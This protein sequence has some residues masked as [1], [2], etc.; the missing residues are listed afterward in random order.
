MQWNASRLTLLVLLL[1]FHN[2]SSFIL[3]VKGG[4]TRVILNQILKINRNGLRLQLSAIKTLN[5][6][7]KIILPKQ[8]C[9]TYTQCQDCLCSIENRCTEEYVDAVDN[10]IHELSSGFAR[11]RLLQRY[12]TGIK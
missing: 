2:I 5:L 3:T 10:T 1:C 6:I 4:T 11:F 12:L 7:K 9:L 8:Q